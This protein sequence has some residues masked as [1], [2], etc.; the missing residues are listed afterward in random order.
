[1]KPTLD[2]ASWAR[3]GSAWGFLTLAGPAGFDCLLQVLGNEWEAV[4]DFIWTLF[5]FR[6]WG[7][8]VFSLKSKL[9]PNVNQAGGKLGIYFLL[10]CLCHS[11]C[12]CRVTETE[13]LLRMLF[14]CSCALEEIKS[15]ISVASQKISPNDFWKWLENLQN[16][17]HYALIQMLNH[18]SSSVICPG[19]PSMWLERLIYQKTVNSHYFCEIPRLWFG[20][21]P[22]QCKALNKLCKWL[23]MPG[24]KDDPVWRRNNF[25][26]YHRALQHHE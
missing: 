13:L 3:R 1:M 21:P 10:W 7:A 12:V 2:P 16:T 11:T 8:W 14:C 25:S 9:F 5:V 26:G 20:T 24:C 18:H 6:R 19:R 23:W 22:P 17:F 15:I 4:S